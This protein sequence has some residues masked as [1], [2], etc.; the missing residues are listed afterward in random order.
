MIAGKLLICL[1]RAL[2]VE[3]STAQRFAGKYDSRYKLIPIITAGVGVP[4]IPKK[5][6]FKQY[7]CFTLG[8]LV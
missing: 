8:N 5:V 1:Q 6:F 3:A 4:L 2:S 7:N